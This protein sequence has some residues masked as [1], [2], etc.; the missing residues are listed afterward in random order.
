MPRVPVNMP[1]MSMTMEF[2]IVVEWLVGV[3]DAVRDGDVLV[4]VTTDK[5]DMEVESTFDG[6][7]EE[8]IAPEGA[9]LDVGQPMAYLQTEK[10]DLLGDLFAAPTAA[11]EVA[12]EAA[13]S[14]PVAELVGTADLAGTPAAGT[15]DAVAVR[16]VPLARRIAA[17]AGIDL[18]TVA[19]TGPAHTI[20]ARDVREEIAGRARQQEPAQV[21]AAAPSSTPKVAPQATGDLLGDGRVR[22]LRVATANVMAASA[23]IPQFTVYRVLDLGRLARARET[24]LKG[25][26]WTSILVRAYALVLREYPQLNGTWAGDG[27]RANAGVGVA[28]AVDTPR[29]LLAPVIADP[30]RLTLRQLDAK[31]RDIAEAIKR[32]DID[33][34]LFSGATGTVSNLGGMGVDRFNALLTPPQATALSLGK[35]GRRPTVD[36]DGELAV[37]IACEV[38]L[39]L[40]HRVAD[41]ADAARALEAMQTFL[42]DPVLLLA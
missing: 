10:A 28:L 20:R 33:P 14:A 9:Q 24:S 35:V 11:P 37:Q 13:A 29:G 30:D 26:S 40:D 15:D 18:R 6:V 2:G 16:A 17:E 38:G 31:V 4:V 12:P 5:V 8:I 23:A 21:A 34:N 19:A 25:V 32:G 1:K 27:V 36:A 22:R 3:G 7:V 42:A 39:T 41:G